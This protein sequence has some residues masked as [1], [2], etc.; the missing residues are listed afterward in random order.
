M[1]IEQRFEQGVLIVIIKETSCADSR[2]QH[3]C[4]GSVAERYLYVL[5]RLDVS[6][7][8]RKKDET[9]TFLR[10]LTFTKRLDC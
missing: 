9:K 3:K 8:H 7:E 5:F 10:R 4:V 1:N 2:W 6:R